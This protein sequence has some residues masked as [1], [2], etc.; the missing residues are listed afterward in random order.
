MDTNV[1]VKKYVG[2]DVMENNDF[3]ILLSNVIDVDIDVWQEDRQE[4]EQIPLFEDQEWPSRKTWILA[5]RSVNH[6]DD[7]IKAWDSR[8]SS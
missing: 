5:L 3:E 6:E 4:P 2:A 1:K 8:Q 7:G